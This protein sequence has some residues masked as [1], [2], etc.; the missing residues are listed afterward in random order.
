MTKLVVTSFSIQ[1]NLLKELDLV[2]GDC[3]RSKYL[4][5]LVEQSIRPKEEAE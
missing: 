4:T 2:R 1:K 3:P 5:R